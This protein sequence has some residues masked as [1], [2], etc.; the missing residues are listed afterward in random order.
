M[1]TPV[2]L[3]PGLSRKLKKVLEFRTDSPDLVA[4]L[5]TLSAFYNENTPQSRRHL[6]STIEDRSLHLN[7]EFLQA[8][9]TAQQ[10]NYTIKL[11]ILLYIYF[12]VI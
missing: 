11:R 3:A 10:V 2:G 4:S 8:S 9:H 7:H 12:S 1:G 5:N 6:R